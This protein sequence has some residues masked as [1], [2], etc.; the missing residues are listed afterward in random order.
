MDDKHLQYTLAIFSAVTSLFDAENENYAFSLSDVD[1]TA[2]FTAFVYAFALAYKRLT[3]EDV[4][5]L[6][7]VAIANR[8]VV[9]H[10]L[11]GGE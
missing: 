4:D 11:E 7:V 9:Q 3:D 2:F 1:P 5:M 10:L 8:L 6:E